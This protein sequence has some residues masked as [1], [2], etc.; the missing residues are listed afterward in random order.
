[1]TF[2][3]DDYKDVP[4]RI[5]EFRTKHPDGSLR[6]LN[7]DKPY[8]IV[9][10]DGQTFVVVVA[11]AF[12]TPDDPAPGVGMAWEPFPGKTPYTKLSELQNAETSAWGRAI[13]AVLASETKQVASREDVRN[14]QPE[15]LADAGT[16]AA[17]RNIVAN[18]DDR[19]RDEFA[20]WWKSASLP[21]LKGVDRLTESQARLAF[22]Y[23]DAAATVPV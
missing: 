16:H 10:L 14:R 11:A 21:S 9:A 18:L 20:K 13:V 2:S 5:A 4:T 19:D 12:R 23:L 8:E 3:L 6:P 15:P 22:D 17:I 7:P 1:M